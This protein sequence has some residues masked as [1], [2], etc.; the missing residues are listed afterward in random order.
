[1]SVGVIWRLR[2]KIIWRLFPARGWSW[3]MAIDWDF[4]WVSTGSLCIWPGLPHRPCEVC[5]TG[6]G[7]WVWRVSV[8]QESEAGPSS[9]TSCDLVLEGTQCHFYYITS[10]EAAHRHTQHQGGVGW[11]STLTEGMHVHHDENNV[12]KVASFMSESLWPYVL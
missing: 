9:V 2:A 10:T 5:L 4:N 7:G 1:M 3:M 12:K 11:V 6:H 8:P